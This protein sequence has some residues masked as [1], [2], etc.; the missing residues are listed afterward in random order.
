MQQN[1]DNGSMLRVGTVLRGTYTIE[2]YLSSGGFGN[3]YRATNSF[4]ETVAIKEFFL[5]NISERD[6]R[7]NSVSVLRTNRE[8]FQSQLEKFRKEAR[9]MRKL[10]S[11]EHL[12]AVHDLFDENGTSYYVMDYVDGESLSSMLR[13]TGRPL[14][15]EQVWGLLPQ[16]LDA[17]SVVHAEGI[18]HLDLK[19]ANIMVDS[20]GVA[21]VIDFGA[22]KQADGEKGGATSTTGAA[23]TNG[24]APREQLEQKFRNFGPWTDIYA[25]GATLY[26]LL[27]NAAEMPMPSDIDDDMTPDKHETLPMPKKVSQPMRNLV[28]WMMQ[29]SRLNRPQSVEQVQAWLS[30]NSIDDNEETLV[31]GVVRVQSDLRATTI[32]PPPAP[33]T[34]PP[35]P[36]T[37]SW[38]SSQPDP[39]P[40]RNW[41]IWASVGGAIVAGFLV[42]LLMSKCGST[43]AGGQN[44][45][46]EVVAPVDTTIVYH[47]QNFGDY[48]YSG[49]T[50]AQGRPDGQ[51]EAWYEDGSR[52]KGS[53]KAGKLNGEGTYYNSDGTYVKGVFRN[54]EYTSDI[55][56][57]DKDGNPL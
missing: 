53:F 29:T 45:S 5:K 51:G 1:S 38:P 36:A 42:F 30:A 7:D 54:D 11:N 27:T 18:W 32:T 35:R 43:P 17:L 52:Y 57:Y 55:Q 56:V 37:S 44:D 41:I 13:R 10:R 14:S 16:V 4:G 9:R 2:G 15:E 21:K 8:L 33:P 24:Y 23:Y 49:D 6:E 31:E 3:T 46:T 34:W 47:S 12:V 19:P 39:K 20:R 50:D 22:S 26:K 28:L 48:R 25:L 40:K